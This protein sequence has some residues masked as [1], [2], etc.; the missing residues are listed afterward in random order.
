MSA[1]QQPLL[2]W[3]PRAG[4]ADLCGNIGWLHCRRV[5]DTAGWRVGQERPRR[6][7]E[8]PARR[9]RARVQARAPACTRGRCAP[10]AADSAS[11]CA[12]YGEAVRRASQVHAP[13]LSCEL[14]LAG[15]RET[16]S[17]IELVEPEEFGL[18]SRSEVALAAREEVRKLRIAQ[19]QSRL[20]KSGR[21]CD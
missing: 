3:R 14:R 12:G 18:T 17:A 11:S 8:H 5:V 13:F 16:A 2:S 19:A 20:A 6:A 21:R 7:L 10:P 1:V 15:H 9:R 4:R